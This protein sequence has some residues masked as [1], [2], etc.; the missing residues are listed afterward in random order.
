[1]SAVGIVARVRLEHEAVGN[2][3]RVIVI[4]RDRPSLIK[5]GRMFST[6]SGNGGPARNASGGEQLGCHCHRRTD[7]TDTTDTFW[8]WL[9]AGRHLTLRMKSACERNSDKNQQSVG[10]VGASVT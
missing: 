2:V 7:T 5:R 10:G 8:R 3:G 1:M 6:S 4:S 9:C